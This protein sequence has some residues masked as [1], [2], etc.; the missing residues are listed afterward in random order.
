MSHPQASAAYA[1]TDPL[2]PRFGEGVT[3]VDGLAVDRFDGLPHLF[4]GMVALTQAA[5]ATQTPMTMMHINVNNANVAHAQ[6]RLKHIYN[7][8]NMLYCDG[9]GIVWGS[10]LMG[11]K[12]PMRFTA[13]DWL[14][15]WVAAMR[16]AGLSIYFVSG[17]PA[18]IARAQAVLDVEVP[19]HTVVGLH[20]GYILKDPA[21]NQ[22]VLADIAAKQPDIVVVGMGCPLQEYWIEDHRSQIKAPVCFAIGATWDYLTGK[23]PRC[24]AWMGNNGLEWLFRFLVEPKRM[25]RRY[26]VGNPEFMWR[27]YGQA[28]RR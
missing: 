19:G 25:F 17:E 20:H 13:A 3:W 4:A 22:A 21:T 2:P 26:I 18:V 11:H 16:D 1:S 23:V 6:P 7:Q 28:K 12:L 15:K 27:V 9:A 10:K 14:L 24:P 5:K 8:A